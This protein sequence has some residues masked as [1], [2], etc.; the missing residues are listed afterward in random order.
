MCKHQSRGDTPDLTI[1]EAVDLYIRRKRINWNGE[2]EETY[3]DDLED[4]ELYAAEFEIESLDDLTRWNL[5]QFTDYLLDQDYSRVTVAGRQKTA[6]T[7]LKFLES[8]G[9]IKPGYHLAIDTLKLTDD[10]ETSD[11]QLTSENA[12]KLLSFY[13][14]SAE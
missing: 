1:S 7:W 11:Q 6:K 4:F 9:A 12:Q 8:Q 13:R 3:Q 14:K 2:T 10:E 5:G